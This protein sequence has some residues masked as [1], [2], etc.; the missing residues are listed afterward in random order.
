MPLRLFAKF[1]KM[2]AVTLSCLE[3]ILTATGRDSP[4]AEAVECRYPLSVVDKLLQMRNSQVTLSRTLTHLAKWAENGDVSSIL[5]S[6][7]LQHIHA[8]QLLYG[9]A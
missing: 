5:G 4:R 7:V 1:M 8:G 2:P 3:R 9:T 6:E